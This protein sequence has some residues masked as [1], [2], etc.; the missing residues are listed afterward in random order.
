MLNG[1]NLKRVNAQL[2]T[3][4]VRQQKY[5]VTTLKLMSSH[6]PLLSMMF[7]VPVTITFNNFKT[8]KITAH[9]QAQQQDLAQFGNNFSALKNIQG[10]LSGDVNLSGTLE[11]PIVAGQV[12]VTNASLQ[13]PAAGS[14][15]S[16]LNLSVTG[17]NNGVLNYAGDLN[18]GTG[19]AS[20]TGTTKLQQ[21]FDTALNFKGSQLNVIHLKQYQVTLSPDIKLTMLD[22]ML[23][24]EGKI[25]IPEA[26]ITP[27]QFS[28]SVNLPEET[29]FIG[30][31]KSS[32]DSLFNALPALQLQLILADKIHVRFEQ[33]DTMLAGS[34]TLSKS[35]QGSMITTGELHTNKGTYEA[36]KKLLTI[37]TGKLIYTGNE[38]TNPGLDIV[39]TR[40]IRTI[41]TE[42][43]QSQ[44]IFAG[45]QT[46]MIGVQ[47]TGTLEK[48]HL[49]MIANPTGL[50]QADILS[51]LV[52]GVPAD[53][54]S[55]EKAQVLMAAASALNMT[56][57][58]ASKFGTMFEKLKSGLGLSELNVET[59]QTY[60]P[61][62]ATGTSG[63]T[64]FV[65]GR[66]LAHNLFIHYS[67]GLFDPI[68]VLNLRY[69]LSKHFSIQTEASRIDTGG[70][71]LYGIERN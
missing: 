48:P 25:V 45:S 2:D 62:N 47:A 71:I 55:G 13:V 32:P 69:K 68:W 56:G 38:L 27:T 43:A 46:V 18:I 42:S 52:L 50:S 65:L 28:D 36:Y 63:T 70:D 4:T 3:Q 58:G 11:K 5:F 67:I 17:D 59:V 22:K 31:K 35:A 21:S 8:K 30:E 29:V 41:Q 34:L 64:S 10:H 61:D 40:P 49:A 24:L 44:Q 60:D 54:A 53:Q 9:L 51:Y 57:S 37:Q 16:N 15:V 1:F 19:K 66:E 14:T 20:L 39:A 23:K 12:N 6:Q 7:K 33:L 26:T